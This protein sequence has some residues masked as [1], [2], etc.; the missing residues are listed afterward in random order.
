MCGTQLPRQAC[1]HL[2]GLELGASCEVFIELMYSF[3]ILTS[4][5]SAVVLTRYPEDKKNHIYLN[6]CHWLLVETPNSVKTGLQYHDITWY[7]SQTDTKSKVISG[8]PNN[9]TPF[10]IPTSLGIL[11]GIVWQS[12]FFEDDIIRDPSKLLDLTEVP[13]GRI[14]LTG[15]VGKV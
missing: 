15:K 7:W 10:T 12:R 13:M 8:A 3:I 14:F 5:H 9:G 1:G 4:S 2:P 6:S 11:M